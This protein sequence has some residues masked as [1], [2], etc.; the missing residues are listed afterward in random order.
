MSLFGAIQL[1]GNSLR[2]M[3]IGLQVVGNNIANANTPGYIR[4]EAIYTPAPV[5]RH[6]RLILGLGVEV[7]SI[8]QK[9]DRFV[10]ER[11]VGARSDRA[12]AETLEQFYRDLEV[13]LNELSAEVDLSSALTG[14]FNAETAERRRERRGVGN[15]LFSA[16]SAT[17]AL[18]ALKG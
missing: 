10:Q 4:Q 9:L 3:Q 12:A 15:F 18:S 11:L 6:G 5:Q 17:S 8:V 16:S 2:A 7:D 13:L 14:F 1:G